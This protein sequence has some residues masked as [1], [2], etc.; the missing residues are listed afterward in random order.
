MSNHLIPPECHRFVSG[1]GT[2]T[3]ALEIM[4]N[5]HEGIENEEIVT[6]SG[7]DIS[8]AFDCIN[9][10]KLLR[11]LTHLGVEESSVSLLNSYFE[12]RTVKL[13]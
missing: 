5:I 6:L 2:L 4:D 10:R 9:R 1:R 3:A 7:I 8:S 13:R 11:I 12:G